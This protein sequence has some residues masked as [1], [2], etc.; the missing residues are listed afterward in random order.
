MDSLGVAGLGVGSHGCAERLAVCSTGAGTAVVHTVF[1]VTVYINDVVA[2]S[3]G[4]ALEHCAGSLGPNF[5]FWVQS[6]H[7][8]DW[9]GEHARLSRSPGVCECSSVCL[10]LTGAGTEVVVG[11]SV[12]VTAQTANL[13]TITGLQGDVCAHRAIP[14]DDDA[15]LSLDVSEET[16]FDD[17]VFGLG[18]YSSS[19]ADDHWGSTD[20]MEDCVVDA[21]DDRLGARH[22]VSA[23]WYVLGGDSEAVFLAIA[24]VLSENV[25]AGSLELV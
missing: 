3:K 5:T 24:A 13:A 11:A 6:A 21:E 22:T 19:V 16:G 2:F 4:L 23:A 12:E 14:L 9:G 1:E 15:V 18:V 25:R 8:L 7:G 10:D 17:L 20:E